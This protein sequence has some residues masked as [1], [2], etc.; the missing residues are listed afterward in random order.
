[1][2]EKVAVLSLSLAEGAT[3]TEAAPGTP[4]TSKAFVA[5]LS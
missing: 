3:V 2:E 4:S 1:M 5:S